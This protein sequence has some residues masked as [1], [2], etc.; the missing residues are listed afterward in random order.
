MANSKFEYVRTFE[1]EETLLPQ[2][3][4]VIRI[5]GRGFHKLSKHYTFTKPNDARALGLMNA[6]A[7]HVLHSI[8]DILVA[9]GVSDEFSFVFD[10][11]TTLFDRRRDKLVST[12][13]STFT[14][15]YVAL[16]DQIQKNI[17]LAFLPTFDSRAIL[18]PSV[19]TLRDYLAWR[20]VDCHINNLYNTT[21]WA[22]GTVASDK[23]EI[24]WSQFGINY[25]NE[26]EMFR[27]GSVVFREYRDKDRKI[28]DGSMTEHIGGGGGE[29]V[30]RTQQ[31]KRKKA[32]ARAEIVVKHCDIIKDDFWDQR[33]WLMLSR[34]DGAGG[35]ETRN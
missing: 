32:R 4:I 7:K 19:S 35:K 22:L 18:Y 27:K 28:V 17:D 33:P 30:S 31:E 16:F 9:Y 6:A 20:Q 15:A 25:N 23:N 2:T 24:L 3:W 14:A 8:P 12:V 10:R 21:F 5:D 34:R 13:V 1:R 11:D 29:P 26:P